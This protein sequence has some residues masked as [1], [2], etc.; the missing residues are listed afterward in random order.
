M[1]TTPDTTTT[2]RNLDAACTT[3]TAEIARSD[4]KA[5]LLLTFTGAVLAGGKT[6]SGSD[7]KGQNRTLL[8]A[9]SRYSGALSN[10]RRGRS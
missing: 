7:R 8:P 9:R 10:L 2:D 4:S 3:V 6:R 1:T 5:S